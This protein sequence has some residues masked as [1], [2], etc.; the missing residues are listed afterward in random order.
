MRIIQKRSIISVFGFKCRAR[1]LVG[2]NIFSLTSRRAGMKNLL[3][4]FCCITS[5]SSATNVHT[6]VPI[7]SEDIKIAFEKEANPHTHRIWRK[8]C[9]PSPKLST[10]LCSCTQVKEGIWMWGRILVKFPVKCQSMCSWFFL[11]CFLLWFWLKY[12][13][14]C[15]QTS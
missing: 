13:V 10:Y 6:L 8:Y 15:V 5:L 7:Q 14:V 9:P 3:P 11:Q 2:I 4:W 1:L 12:V